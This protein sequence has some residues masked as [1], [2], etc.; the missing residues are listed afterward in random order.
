MQTEASTNS[1]SRSAA[2]V[3][4]VVGGFTTE[5]R[6]ARGDGLRV[7]RVNLQTG[8]W[9]PLHHLSDLTNPS[10]LVTGPKRDILYAAHGDCDYASAF[11]ID[12]RNGSLRLLGQAQTGGVNGVHLAVDPSGRFLLVAN[13]AT[14]SVSVLPIRPDGALEPFIHR[15]ELTGEAGPHRR[16]QTHS[17]PHHIVFDP[18]GRFVLVPDKGL[19]RVFVLALD[20]HTGRL[21]PNDG[22]HAAMRPGAGPRHIAFHPRLPVAFVINEL[23]S[24]VAAC[25]WDDGRGILTQF[26]AAPTLPPDYFGASTAAA[27]VVSQCGRYV[28]AS[29]R[30]QDGIARLKF[31][32]DRNSLEVL[33]W[34]SS[35]GRDPRF[36]CLDP[37]GRVLLA[38]NEQSD[39]IASFDIGIE[40]GGLSAKEHTV[41]VASPATIA[42]V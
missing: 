7:F 37:Q 28:F 23:D 14:G 17:H 27:I 19:D 2:D 3:L 34:T 42:F 30:G 13:Y 24:T 11:A 6:K 26:W 18:S 25:R 10:F 1:G 9:N 33:G 12:A 32:E 15:L 5:Q 4:A 20:P 8:A 29:N 41:H 38:A 40:D 22:G 36:M 39:T 21:Q 35:Q 16:E 31:D